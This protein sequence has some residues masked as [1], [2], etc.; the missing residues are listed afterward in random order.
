MRIIPPP[1]FPK[2]Q[3]TNATLFD[4]VIICLRKYSLLSKYKGYIWHYL[5]SLLTVMIK[6]YTVSDYGKL[7]I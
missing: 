1:P 4:G 3:S 5:L 2:I 7:S 6:I